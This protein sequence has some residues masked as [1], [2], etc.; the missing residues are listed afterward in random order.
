MK[1]YQLRHSLGKTI[2]FSFCV[3]VSVAGFFS[4]DSDRLN[5]G[6]SI[7]MMSLNLTADTTNIKGGALSTKAGNV[8]EDFEDVDEYMVQIFQESDTLTSSLYKDFPEELEIKEGSY[9]LRASKGENL[10]AA[11]DNPYFEGSTDFVIKKDM[12]TPLE[13]TCT[14][15]NAR[16]YAEYSEDFLKAYSDYSVLLKTSYLDGAFTIAKGETRGA[17][18]QVEKEGTPLSV[19]ISLMRETWKEPKV[20]TVTNPSITIK[21]K[22]SVTLKFATDGKTGDGLELSIELDDSMEEAE[23][24]FG[25]PDFMWKPF[26]DL[27]IWPCGFENDVP[28]EMNVADGYP[29]DSCTVKAE[30]PGRIKECWVVRLVDGTKIDSVDIATAEGLKTAEEVWGLSAVSSPIAGVKGLELDLKGAF[31]QMYAS[32]KDKI[33][34]F[35]IYVNDALNVMHTSEV[36]TASVNMKAA[37]EPSVGNFEFTVPSKHSLEK[38]TAIAIVA[39]AGIKALTL[40]VSKDG[41]MQAQYNVLSD[42]LPEGISYDKQN[43]KIVFKKE[44]SS[45][46]ESKETD[47]STYSYEVEVTDNLDKTVT[48]VSAIEVTPVFTIIVPEGDIWTNRATI[49]VVENV[50]YSKSYQLKVGGQW[51]DYSDATIRGLQPNT[52][53]TVRALVNNWPTTEATFTT[54]NT[55]QLPNAGFEEWY[56]TKLEDTIYGPHWEVWY[57]GNS[58]ISIWNTLNLKTTSEGGN[59]VDDAYRYIANS[60]TIRTEDK[61]SGNYAALI[62]SVG[63]GVGS[64][65]GGKISI[66]KKADPGYLY[67]GSYNSSTQAGD[68]GIEFESRPSGFKFYCKYSSKSGKDAFI[69]KMVVL[70]A[71]DNIIAEGELPKSESTSISNYTQKTVQLTYKTGCGKAKKMYILFQSGTRLDKNK[72]THQS[73]DF[74]CPSF[75][76]LSNGEF[77]GSQLYIDDVELIYE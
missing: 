24:E 45:K 29:N 39:E 5:G 9:T 59:G 61:N 27:R 11:Y 51:Q 15:A 17:Y 65:A 46:L 37:K 6:G 48:K 72:V 3:W 43:R 2:A 55:L 10:P 34:G 74:S 49:Q 8:L 41:V 42:N 18:L 12:K 70:D 32:D 20:Y 25:I 75:G 71:S 76:N 4:C 56:Y 35:S 66:Q 31:N 40:K 1:E 57:L 58:E 33:Y 26:T 52:T 14:M 60:G 22:E 21:P 68:Y 23:L 28:V 13:V 67:L 7:G 38:D 50:T 47:A 77:V 64:T 19:A 73:E 16:V 53:Y 69:A 44:C 63:W 30:V 54:E 36:I 62:R